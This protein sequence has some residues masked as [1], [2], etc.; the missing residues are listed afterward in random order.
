MLD[1]MKQTH[2]RI[3]GVSEEVGRQRVAERLLE[4]VMAV[5]FPNVMKYM[6]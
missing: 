1:A 2:I 3:T 4:K 6:I 5:N